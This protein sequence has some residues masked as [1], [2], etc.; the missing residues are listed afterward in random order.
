MCGSKCDL[1]SFPVGIVSDV[2]ANKDSSHE[3]TAGFQWFEQLPT[4][5]DFPLVMDEIGKSRSNLLSHRVK[6]G[7][8]DDCVV[9]PH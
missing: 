1:N 5:Y 7:S 8:S 3:G 6:R 9:Q 4:S 2:N